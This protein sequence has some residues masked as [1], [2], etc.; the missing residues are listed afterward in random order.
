[1]TAHKKTVLFITGTRAEWGLIEST[2]L[3]LKKSRAFHTQV[4]V[5]GMHTQRRFGYTIEHVRKAVHV[6]HVVS[7]GEHDDPLT[8][9]AKEIDGIGEYLRMHLVDAV[10][11]VADRDEAF[12]G[13]VAAMHRGIPVI[14]VSG[15]DTT[16]PTVDE[17]LRKSI[18]LFSSVHLVQTAQ[19][20]SNVLNL[21]ADRRW[22]NVVGS[23]G[24][25]G[26][27]PRILPKRKDL[28]ARYRLDP[29][30]RWHLVV[31]HPSALEDTPITRQ[32]DAV[33]GALKKI[34]PQDEKI[35]LYPNSDAGSEAF[36]HAI[37][38]FQRKPHYH[39]HRHIERKDYLGLMLQSAALVGNTSSGLVEAG[40]LR[41]PFV[42]IGARQDG[43]EHGP[44]VIFTNYDA[45]AIANAVRRASSSAFHRALGRRS[46]P[47]KGGAVAERITKTIEQFLRTL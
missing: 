47:Y 36:I 31:M 24:L 10:L 29:K 38:R 26:L 11:V 35:I 5:T 17:Y 14:H 40:Y 12:A 44:N 28:A 3:R 4:L 43:R 13:A 15:G 9:L 27:H 22:A 7:V 41:V 2:I 34:D 18:T 20:K 25:D 6:D 46:S 45:V 16:G 39:L 21:G 1:M 8:A 32:I 33:L 19:S 30:K 42:N 37:E 23:A